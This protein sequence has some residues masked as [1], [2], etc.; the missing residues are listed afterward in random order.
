MRNQYHGS[1]AIQT[2]LT[3]EAKHCLVVSVIGFMATKFVQSPIPAHRVL[4]QISSRATKVIKSHRLIPAT[5]SWT[6]STSFR[7]IYTTKVGEQ[8]S[9]LVEDDR[10]TQDSS[11]KRTLTQIKTELL[12]VVQGMPISK[13]VLILS[14]LISLAFTLMSCIYVNYRNQ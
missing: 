14:Y 3:T 7:S 6:K 5:H 2:E 10:E 12:Q 11:D 1:S 8:S 4:P 9:G 13:F